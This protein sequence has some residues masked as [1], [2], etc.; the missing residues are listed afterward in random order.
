[1]KAV[2]LCVVVG[3]AFGA[4]LPAAA[5]P[6][7]VL[8]S[9]DFERSNL[10]PTWSRS[11][12]QRAGTSAATANSGS[13][14]MYTRHDPV[15]VTL[16]TAIDLAVPGARLTAWIRRGSDTFSED[17]D[18]GE[19][20]VLEYFSAGGAWV[21]LDSL[22]GGGIDGEILNVSYLLGPDALH[23]GF[24]LR[25][26]QTAGSGNDWDYWH[27][28]DVTVTETEATALQCDDFDDGQPY[29]VSFNGGG[30]VGVSG[31]TFSSSPNAMT[32]NGGRISVDSA[33]KDTSS[34]LQFLSVW[35]RRGADAFSED[36]DNGENLVLQYRNSVGSWITLETFL[37]SGSKGQ[38][39]QRTYDLSG[40]PQATHSSFQI[41]WTMTNGS[42][43]AWDFWHI[44]D[45]CLSTLDATV[46]T[47]ITISHDLL[48]QYCVTE[49][50]TLSVVDTSGVPIADYVGTVDLSVS[51]GAG[52]WSVITG[53][54]NLSDADTS[55]GLASYTFNASDNGSVVLGLTYSAGAPAVDIDGSESSGATDDDSEGLLTFS[56]SGITITA[57][58][59]S[60][61]PPGV[62]NDPIGPQTAGVDF[63]LHLAAFGGTPEDATCGV[64]EAI[65]GPRQ[66]NFW[67][68]WENPGSG[69]VTATV[70]G[71]GC[72]QQSS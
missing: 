57:N 47:Q 62:I 26:R 16:N 49:P 69:S 34:G 23:A 18:P 2:V 13:R 19:D 17:P 65:D 38:V 45:V 52:A 67:Q 4:M 14:S 56:P 40:T 51:T 68:S 71:T 29:S 8:F 10:Q 66:V 44:D 54:G 27:I 64:I 46:P 5:A 12:S 7:D 70:G 61:P 35:V 60:N 36:T 9:D 53:A 39:Y 15:S 11:S 59:L 24:L 6:G 1:M 37:G 63:E 72:G 33:V 22:D 31:A 28:D 55:D 48:G 30:F 32:L 50:V 42:G 43:A 58:Q 21:V 25:F 41:R 20:L 3:V